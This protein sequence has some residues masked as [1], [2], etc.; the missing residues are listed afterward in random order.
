MASSGRYGP[1]DLNHVLPS[2]PHSESYPAQSHP[3]EPHPVYG[4]NVPEWVRQGQYD[5]NGPGLYESAFQTSEQ[6]RDG[7]YNLATRL[8]D[9]VWVDPPSRSKGDYLRW[10][11]IRR[12]PVALWNAARRLR[13]KDYHEARDRPSR[14]F[15][16]VYSI[17]TWHGAAIMDAWPEKAILMQRFAA[18]VDAPPPLVF[19]WTLRSRELRG[20]VEAHV[21]VARQAT[22]VLDDLASLTLSSRVLWTTMSIMASLATTPGDS[23]LVEAQ[24]VAACREEL[25]RIRGALAELPL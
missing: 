9:D 13:A 21:A 18:T 25:A 12:Y 15:A 20:T 5:R 14:S 24:L 3:A 6:Q 19:D 11:H 1:S 2:Q 8:L 16:G 23:D 22:D 17:L 7:T 4:P 10:V